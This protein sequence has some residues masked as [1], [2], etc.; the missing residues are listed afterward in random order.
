MTSTNNSDK[1]CSHPPCQKEVYAVRLCRPHYR[2]SRAGIPLD[3]SREVP[4]H[5]TQDDCGEPHVAKGLCRSHYNRMRYGAKHLEG[6]AIGSRPDCSIEGCDKRQHRN[7]LCARHYAAQ[8]R[9]LSPVTLCDVELCSS[10]AVS[11]G[12]C[13]G[14]YRRVFEGGG[15]VTTPLLARRSPAEIS[16]RN[17]SGKKL[18]PSCECWLSE[19]EFSSATNTS[20]GLQTWCTFCKGWRRTLSQFN[21]TKE[22]FREMLEAQGNS[23][24]ICGSDE[25]GKGIAAWCVDHD[26]D[27]CNGN[28]SCGKCVRGLLCRKCNTGLGMFND[29]LESIYNAFHYLK[30]HHG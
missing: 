9:E 26:H 11:R 3:Y 28:R 17:S 14:H 5:C 15:D 21:L 4:T 12:Y 22:R 20:D 10:K 16:Y 23:C 27:C 24:A 1:I 29:K 8:R 19:M 7:K 6:F 25:P 13:D 30:D 2:R 18:C